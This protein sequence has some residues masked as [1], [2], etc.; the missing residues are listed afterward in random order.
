MILSRRGTSS[1]WA[2][3]AVVWGGFFLAMLVTDL[4]RRAPI[5]S[6]HTVV[7]A[8]VYPLSIAF[9]LLVMTAALMARSSWEEVWR[10]LID[11][12]PIAFLIAT[13]AGIVGPWN[14]GS[15]AIAL[16]PM[17][18]AMFVVTGGALPVSVGPIALARVLLLAFAV[19][20]G[21]IASRR[22][23]GTPRAIL[24]AIVSWIAACV[25]L[26][27]QSWIA[28][29]AAITRRLPLEHSLDAL[30]ALGVAVT[31][32]YWS[33]A[34]AD[35]FLSGIGDQV[36]IASALSA[37]AL[38]LVL[39]A[40]VLAWRYLSVFVSW[41]RSYPRRMLLL[42]FS[43][44]LAGFLIGI[45]GTRMSWT[46]LDILAVVLLLC[47]VFAWFV[48]DRWGTERKEIGE[49]ACLFAFASGFVMGW[50]V[51]ALLAAL[52]ALGS[53][54]MRSMLVLRASIAAGILVAIGGAAA[55]R[56]GVFPSALFD[57]ALLWG[58][59]TACVIGFEKKIDSWLRYGIILAIGMGWALTLFRFSLPS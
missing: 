29:G 12:S 14:D 52:G 3:I 50:P 56:S 48:W 41:I 34:Q 47:M 32:S 18:A 19:M 23:F 49:A 22:G 25:P 44:L 54:R 5:A 28:L 39:I 9:C 27:A 4:V 45:R 53:G 6:F 1:V 43:P 30:R 17:D 58:V 2:D 24:T 33:N 36:G 11:A 7:F 8:Y 21:L 42:V 57:I 46:G 31:H 38:G 10:G 20:T 51:V 35:R 26:L 55:V 16:A 37:A 59:L 15:G 40:V 13:V